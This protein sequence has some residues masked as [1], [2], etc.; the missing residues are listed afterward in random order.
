MASYTRSFGTFV[1]SNTILLKQSKCGVR[2]LRYT[3]NF[4]KRVDQNR[5]KLCNNLVLTVGP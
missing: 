4:A 1:R 5:L 2:F 3:F